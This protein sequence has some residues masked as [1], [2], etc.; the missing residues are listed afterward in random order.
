MSIYNIFIVILSG[1]RPD[2]GGSNGV[3]G[4][5]VVRLPGELHEI[6]RL[7]KTSLSLRFAS[8]RMTIE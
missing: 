5:R 7:R 8:L 6:L 1:V 2:E 4:S 3:E